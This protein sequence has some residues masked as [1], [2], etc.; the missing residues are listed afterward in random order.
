METIISLMGC[1]IV[2]LGLVGVCL[3]LDKLLGWL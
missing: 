3:I 1:A 2:V